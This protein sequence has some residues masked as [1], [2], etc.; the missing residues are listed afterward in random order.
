MAT[1]LNKKERVYDLQLTSYGR[2][3]LSIGTFKPVYYTFLDDNIL[4]DGAYAGLTESQNSIAERIRG[5]QYLE[6]LV[7]FAD[8]GEHQAGSGGGPL[9]VHESIYS[10]ERTIPRRDIFNINS[11]IGD[12]KLED[13]VEAT[14]AWKVVVLQG[15]I[16]SSQYG[17]FRNDMDIPQVNISLNYHLQV[18]KSEFMYNP[19]ASLNLVGETPPFIDDRSIKLLIDDAM[20]YVEEANTAMLTENYDIEVFKKVPADEPGEGHAY[21]K[22][23]LFLVPTSGDTIWFSDGINAVLFTFVASASSADEVT[24]G[25]DILTSSR[26][27]IEKIN[28]SVL[29]ISAGMDSAVPMQI[30]L[31]SIRPGTLGNRLIEISTTVPNTIVGAGMLGG[32]PTDDL[33]IRKYFQ[34]EVPQIQDGY[35]MSANPGLDTADANGES[36]IRRGGNWTTSSVEYYFDVMVDSHVNQTKACEGAEA[37]NKESYY[38]D[39][40]FECGK[41][42][43][44]SI[45]YDIYGSATEPEICQS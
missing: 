22:L 14:P 25:A 16:T 5:N 43:V 42:L 18:Q 11:M 40:D 34:R 13:S 35:M 45:F 36:P 23:W 44:E 29:K 1:F 10:T 32:K 24:I 12:M 27:L 31:I 3:L 9:N 26:N 7:L 38:V 19:E 41:Q 6:S 28:D 17:D 30:N 8:V 2:Y 15:E 37:F 39:F 21:G 20:I 4:Y 33:L